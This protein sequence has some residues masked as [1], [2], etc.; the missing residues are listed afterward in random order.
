M[1][2]SGE[3]LSHIG[4][5]YRPGIYQ[6]PVPGYSYAPHEL[7]MVSKGIKI[8]VQFPLVKLLR[9]SS[10]PQDHEDNECPPSCFHNNLF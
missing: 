10:H 8:T 3:A 9:K 2:I 5:P 4:K 6:F 7:I 1:L